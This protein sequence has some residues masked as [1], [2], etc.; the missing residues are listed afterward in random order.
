MDR[1]AAGCF[2]VIAL[3]FGVLIA[4][5]DENAQLYVGALGLLAVLAAVLALGVMLA[6][7]A[8][9]PED[10]DRRETYARVMIAL[11]TATAGTAAGVGGSA[12]ANNAESDTTKATADAAQ[13]AAG[14]AESSANQATEAAKQA[15]ESGR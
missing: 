14:S 3:G 6:R 4:V 12:V 13:Q 15:N 9:G 5:D 1:F 2:T 8:P 7:S 10:R 11:V